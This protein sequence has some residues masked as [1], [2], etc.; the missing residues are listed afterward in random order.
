MRKKK[1]H[2][3]WPVKRR[4]IPFT[5]LPANDTRKEKG[6]LQHIK[7]QDFF[8]KRLHFESEQNKMES[9][10]GVAFAPSTAPNTPSDAAKQSSVIIV[11]EAVGF[12][13]LCSNPDS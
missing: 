5:T 8:S 3:S 6:M 11:R 12:G 10:S 7:L 4:L 2:N 1:K 9:W 13:D